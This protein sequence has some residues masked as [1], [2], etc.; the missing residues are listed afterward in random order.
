MSTTKWQQRCSKCGML[1]KGHKCKAVKAPGG[2]WVVPDDA[3]DCD[4]DVGDFDGPHKG[5]YLPHLLV[6]T[7]LEDVPVF[8]RLEDAQKYC[9]KAKG[10]GVTRELSGRYTVREKAF[11]KDSSSAIVTSWINNDAPESAFR[12]FKI[13]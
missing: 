12:N 4:D 5:K 7:R 3:D 10:G 1:R 2:G 13:Q 9:I 11:L 8:S 6:S